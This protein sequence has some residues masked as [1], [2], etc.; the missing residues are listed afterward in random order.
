MILSYNI[1]RDCFS[2]FFLS[3]LFII[4]KKGSVLR[5]WLDRGVNIY[6]TIW[7]FDGNKNDDVLDEIVV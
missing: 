6:E 2:S 3:A 4:P 1:G 5:K 7:V